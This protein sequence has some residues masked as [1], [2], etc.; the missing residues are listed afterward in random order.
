MRVIWSEPALAN[1]AAIRDYIRR[2]APGRA[3]RFVERLIR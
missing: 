3:D 1:L 2:D